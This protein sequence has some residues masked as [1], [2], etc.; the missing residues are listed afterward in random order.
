LLSRSARQAV[1]RELE[2]VKLKNL[3]GT[4]CEVTEGWKRLSGCCE[5]L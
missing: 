3:H 2:G 1:K 5:D 4:A